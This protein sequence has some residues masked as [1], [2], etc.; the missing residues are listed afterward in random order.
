LA[1][2]LDFKLNLIEYFDENGTFHQNNLNFENGYISRCSKNYKG[3]FSNSKEE[4]DKFYNSI[5]EKNLDQ[6]KALGITYT[7]LLF[8]IINR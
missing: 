1:E 4:L 3:R 2:Q 6:I 7:S 5:P 8:D